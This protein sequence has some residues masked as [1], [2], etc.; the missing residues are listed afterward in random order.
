MKAINKKR[1]SVCALLAAASCFAVGL[2]TVNAKENMS[3]SADGVSLSASEF[4]M[5]TGAQVRIETTGG[6]GIRF[7]FTIAQTGWN[8][9]MQAYPSDTYNYKVYTEIDKTGNED[10]G[11][12]KVIVQNAFTFAQDETEKPF[13]AT[14]IYD[15]LTESEEDLGKHVY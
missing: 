3:A 12:E 14:I 15:E 10:E 4:Y 9:I 11:E 5:E 13:F 1:I 2:S 6:S 7:G 8:K